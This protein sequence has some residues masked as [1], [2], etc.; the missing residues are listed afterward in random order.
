MVLGALCSCDADDNCEPSDNSIILSS[1]SDEMLFLEDFGDERT[2][3]TGVGVASSRTND[4]LSGD[5]LSF[6]EDSGVGVAD[7]VGVASSSSNDSFSSD[8]LLFWKIVV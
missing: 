1:L 2:D 4:L 7:S 5:L 3:D 8:T 6:L